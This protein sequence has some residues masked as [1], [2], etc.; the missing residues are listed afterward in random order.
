MFALG[1][2]TATANAGNLIPPA[3]PSCVEYGVIVNGT[4]VMPQTARWC[5]GVGRAFVGTG[6]RRRV[7]SDHCEHRRPVPALP[8]VV[9]RIEYM[10]F[11]ALLTSPTPRVKEPWRMLF[12]APP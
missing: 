12:P 7:E 8:G 10:S 4:T 3:P 6:D 9:D 2:N 5:S 1:F 11:L